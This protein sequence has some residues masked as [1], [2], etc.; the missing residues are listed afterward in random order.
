MQNFECLIE[1]PHVYR[2]GLSLLRFLWQGAAVAMVV[3]LVTPLLRRRSAAV[4][5]IVLLVALGFMALLPVA[6]FCLVESPAALAA[7]DAAGGGASMVGDESS[8]MGTGLVLPLEGVGGTRG[9]ATDPTEDAALM[10]AWIDWI[11][12]IRPCLPW[13]VVGWCVGV[14]VLSVR[15]TADWL[16]VA[17]LVRR[18]VQPVTDSVRHRAERLCE[19]LKIRHAVTLLESAVVHVPTVVGFWRP[20]ILLPVSALVGLPPAQ[21][22]SLVAHELAHI[23]RYD[24]LANMVQ[25]VVETLLFYHPAVWWLSDRIRTERE[26]CCDDVAVSVVGNRLL[27]AQALVDMAKLR[28]RQRDLAVAASGSD[29]RSRIQ[30]VMGISTDG[31]S[32]PAIW[33]IGGALLMILAL[34][35]S[36]LSADL[37][38]RANRVGA[39]R[40]LDLERQKLQGTWEV[41]SCRS[42]DGVVIEPP[43]S[44]LAIRGSKVIIVIGGES[45]TSE[46]TV[47]SGKDP[48]ELVLKGIRGKEMTAVYSVQQDG[49]VVELD[50]AVAE[51]LFHAGARAPINWDARE[52]EGRLLMTLRRMSAVEVAALERNARPRWKYFSRLDKDKDE[53]LTLEEFLVDY[54]APEA[55]RQG[56][57]LFELLDSDRNDELSSDE[58]K[59]EPRKVLF[60][61]R[62]LNADGV[63]SE[64]EFMRGEM[65]AAPPARARRVF[66]LVDKD[67]DGSVDFG[68]F[69]YRRAEAWFVKL[70][71]S[72]DG[73]MSYDEYADGNRFLERNN[74]YRAVFTAVDQNGDGSLSLDELAN[75]SRQALFIRRDANADQ[76]L[77][78]EEFLFFRRDPEQIAAAKEEF[79]W[80][81]R[82]GDGVLTLEEY[83][84]PTGELDSRNADETEAKSTDRAAPA[85][86]TANEDGVARL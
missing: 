70:D 40:T 59:A 16:S 74:R 68:E 4:R 84:A 72:E 80:R 56:T 36:T 12:Q 46:Y 13:V 78:F 62:D 26:N 81:D 49:A 15:L 57:E 45:I 79:A 61:R 27:Y 21:F 63:L 31:P 38:R 44:W 11:G 85:A 6:T 18:H 67:H 54:P 10:S 71:T 66:E 14:L 47:S 17:R 33:W 65:K 3:T 19:S 24:Y 51:M 64:K 60:L 82:G 53:R 1:Q 23:R 77:T 30:R 28:N 29:L 75:I 76:K 35:M 20:V 43:Y 22:E 58:F 52:S 55:V 39:S 69:L 37:T 41:V 2:L 86:E 32:R 48:N 73:R 9:P 8:E 34:G 25:S 7:T 50:S 5:Y 83:A 42:D